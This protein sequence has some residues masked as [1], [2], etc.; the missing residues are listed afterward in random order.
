[1]VFKN[2]DSASGSTLALS[3]NAFLAPWTPAENCWHACAG[4][5]A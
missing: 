1:M 4:D 3:I 2:E 5:K